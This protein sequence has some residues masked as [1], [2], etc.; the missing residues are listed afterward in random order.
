[1]PARK[2]AFL[3]SSEALHL[4]YLNPGSIRHRRSVKLSVVWIIH[5]VLSASLIGSDV[6]RATNN[7]FILPEAGH[8]AELV[9]LMTYDVPN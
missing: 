4:R 3:N 1:M 7:S 9:S 6:C 5:V 8:L 2:A